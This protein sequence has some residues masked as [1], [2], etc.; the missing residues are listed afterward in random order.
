MLEISGFCEEFHSSDSLFSIRSL[1]GVLT[2][3]ADL[4]P[5]LLGDESAFC[6]RAAWPLVELQRSEKGALCPQ[7]TF[8]F[9][10]KA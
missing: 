10:V 7:D 6:F 2:E 8:V 1:T 4:E 3:A 9:E 5:R